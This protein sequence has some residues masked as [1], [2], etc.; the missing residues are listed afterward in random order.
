MK[1]TRFTLLILAVLLLLVAGCART[2]IAGPEPVTI[3]IAG[4][5]EMLPV[6]TELTAEFSRRNPHVRFSLRGGGS[7]LG[8]SAVAN[9]QVELAATTLLYEDRLLP[10]RVV[11]IPIALDGIAVITHVSNPVE[12]LTLL[13]LRAVYSGKS[14]DWQDVDGTPSEILLVSREDGSGA[15]R[16]FEERVMGE[17]RVAL[18]AVVM[19]TSKDV[20]Q[21]VATHPQAIGYVTQA[22]VT[23]NR[24]TTDEQRSCLARIKMVEVEGVLPTREAVAAQRYHLSR[25]LFLLRRTDNRGWPQQFIDFV[26]SPAGQAIVSRYHT[27][28]R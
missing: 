6:L 3:R 22:Y 9:R 17:D 26:L 25:P 18:T 7:T 5:T 2:G 21:Y 4:S 14:L 28:V 27:R 23:P 20:V 24:A 19:P 15:R 10:P 11:R 12:N 13:Q 16:L 8:E 1:N